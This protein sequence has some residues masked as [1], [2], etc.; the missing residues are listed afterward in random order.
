MKV[1]LG[2]PQLA[3][4]V[5]ALAGL[6][7]SG[8][9]SPPRD[10]LGARFAAERRWH[11]GLL[12]LA[13]VVLLFLSLPVSTPVWENLPLIR[14]V[15]FPWRL[16]GRAA[17]P[18][19]LLAGAVPILLPRRTCLVPLVAVSAVAALSLVSFPWLYP[20][21]CSFPSSPT[22]AT[23][24]DFERSSG[25]TGVDPLGAYL[26]RWVSQRP[27][28]SPMEAALREG[29]TPRRVDS[30][31]HPAGATLL[32]ESYGPNRATIEL[33]TP[34][35]F[36]ATYHT[37]SFPGWTVRID[38]ERIP[39]EPLAETG[40]ISFSVPS[41]RHTLTIRWGSTPLRTGAAIISLLG[42]VALALLS[43]SAASHQI[44]QSLAPPIQRASAWLIVLALA[45]PAIKT[46]LVDSGYTP[47]Y[48]QGLTDE[49]A[50]ALQHARSASFAD[51]LELLG[52]QI[53]RAPA[54]AEFRIDLTWTASQS[55]TGN[56]STRVA[57]VDADGLIW[58]AKETF[59][60]RGYQRHPA[61]PEWRPGAWVWDSHS[62]PILPGTPPG[63]YQLKLT[64]FDRATL[65]PLNVLDSA[66]RVAGPDLVIG[67]LDV[68]RPRTAPLDLPM[69][70]TIN[71]QWG[72]L[73]LLGANLDRAEAA[74]GNPALVTLFWEAKARLPSL[75]ARLELLDPLGAIVREWQI[76]LVREDYPSS[77]WSGDDKLMGQH[78][79]SIPGR[80]G[81]GE[82]TWQLTV[83]DEAGAPIGPSITLGSLTISAPDRLWEMPAAISASDVQISLPSGAPFARLSGYRLDQSSE[84][85]DLTLVWQAQAET[86]TNYRV[87]VHLFAP[88]GGV[89]SQSDGVPAA[90]TRPTLGWRPGEY[91]VDEHTLSLPDDP[92]TGEYTL[93]AGLY[94]LA[95]GDRLDASQNIMIKIRVP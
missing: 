41:G 42:L 67:E 56:Y 36:Q 68:E 81:N 52:Y 60:P 47:L 72:D 80:V 30:A 61:T 57:L 91:I 39:I 51:G 12:T 5:I 3:L 43:R 59:R 28:S 4:G 62:V 87:F 29:S 35:R 10:V 76:P 77:D 15:Q 18:L 19:A 78:P 23:V 1:N 20:T 73:A 84:E 33:E 85:L 54:G 53:T 95:T 58:S 32:R 25:L 65:A 74:P 8:H 22:I 71:E 11:A 83:L 82:H 9:D 27:E 50:P 16:V 48:R 17:L 37:F 55:P 92:P 63:T 40:L 89:V 26:P 46:G 90:W 14:F 44:G 93:V 86:E 24:M 45:L 13:T 34:A 70:Y 64:V 38:G 49:Q 75:T 66:G 2:L 69:Q 31:S 21:P 94:D 7:Y 6:L 88:D 79:L